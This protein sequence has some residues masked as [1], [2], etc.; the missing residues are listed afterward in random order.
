MWLYSH[1]DTKIIVWSCLVKRNNMRCVAGSTGEAKIYSSCRNQ[2]CLLSHSSCTS[3][4]SYTVLLMIK[5]SPISPLNW[6]HITPVRQIKCMHG[7][8]WYKQPTCQST[9]ESP[10][11]LGLFHRITPSSIWVAPDWITSIIAFTASLTVPCSFVTA[12]SS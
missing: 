9:N 11:F 2:S 8:W 5:W 1:Y 6:F 4:N 12:F 7:G 10:A 3:Y